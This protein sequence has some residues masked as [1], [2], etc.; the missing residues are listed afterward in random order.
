MKDYIPPFII[1]NT[2]LDCISNIM[3][4]IGK[5]DYYKNL[6]RMPILRKNNRIESIHSSLAI[7]ANS[8][9]LEQVSDVI[10]GKLVRG[11]KYE[12]DEVKNA[13]KACEMMEEV[14]PFNLDD[15]KKIH[16]VM[17][18]S[19]IDDAGSYRRGKEGVFDGEKCIF[20]APGPEMVDQLM[21]G[22]FLWLQNNQNNIHPLILSSV[23]HYEFVFIHPFSDGNGR[24]ARV[25]QNIILGNW[26][27]LFY[28]LPIESQIK[29]YQNEY[30]RVIDEC[31]H[32][33]NSTLFIEFMLR[34]I[35]EAVQTVVFDSNSQ[36]EID[37]PYI[38]K[39]LNVMDDKPMKAIDIMDKLGI[40]SRETFRNTYLDPAIKKGF[41]KLTIPDKPTSKNQMYYKL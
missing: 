40:K 15:L 7:E 35:Q 36:S 31:N 14:D 10:N 6:N 41:V 11:P 32:V 33:G 8:L 17:M 25:W 28:Y 22:L 24:M 30:Y 34:M 23:F 1:T 2:M 5:M 18:N 4:N 29:K 20:M 38:V 26:K 16:G 39:L 37:N 9:S 13:Y 3:E 12:I 21:Q 19:L 27:E